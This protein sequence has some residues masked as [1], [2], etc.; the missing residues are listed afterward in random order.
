MEIIKAK[1]IDLIEILYLLRVC[2]LDMNVKGLKHWNSA[3]PGAET[4]QQDL[5]NGSIYLMKEK[6]V[7]KGMVTL[8]TDEPED[9]YQL[10]FQ[11]GK[12]KPLY[13]QNLAVHPRWQG[14]GIAKLLIE[15]AQKLAREK[16][17]D[18]IRM[19]VF[20]PSDGARQLF[21]KQDFQE[22]SSFHSAYQQIP[23]VCY[24][25]QL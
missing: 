6:G 21:E 3:F 14:L 17:F 23:F 20:K 9:Y 19:D 18:C 7:C 11:S 12:Q 4:V 22:V 25:K 24:E 1:P 8:N 2:I 16:G 10:N 5:D 13:L 15:Y